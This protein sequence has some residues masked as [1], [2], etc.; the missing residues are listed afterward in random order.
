MNKVSATVQK[1]LGRLLTKLPNPVVTRLAGSPIVVDGQTMDPL[2]QFVYR[3]FGAAPGHLPTVEEERE[4]FD[5]QGSWFGHNP[6][7][8]VSVEL[9][10]IDGP[11][12]PIPC[13]MHKPP[14]LRPA[15]APALMYFHGGGH[16]TGSIAS[17]RAL[18]R[19]L[20]VDAEC[21]VIAV[22]YRLAPEHTFPVGINDTLAAYDGVIEQSERLGLNPDKIA[23][24]GDSAGGNIAAVVAQQRKD[25]THPPCFQALWVPWVD[26]SAQ[27]RSYELFDLGYVLEK[28][29]ME[30]YTSMYLNTPEEGLDP[31]ASPLLGDVSGVC[32]AAVFVA[33]FDPLRDEGIAYGEKLKAAGVEVDSF[34]FPGLQ[35]IFV[36]LAGAFPTAR[37][38]YADAVAALRRIL[39]DTSPAPGAPGRVGQRSG[40]SRSDKR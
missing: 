22:D 5:V 18:C 11:V 28:P 14:G 35:H 33:G 9:F 4:Q 34:V 13:E 38:A 26:M 19:Q 29:K 8:G 6:A 31:L 17:H 7:P 36:N 37:S 12:G 25:A 30:W 21:A 16:T 1:T 15:S 40:K 27:S 3:L 23:V 10:S 32:P 24:G 2:T 20:S 39:L